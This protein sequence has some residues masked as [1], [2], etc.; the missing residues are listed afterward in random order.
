MPFMCYFGL[1]L[2]CTF[3]EVEFQYPVK[4]R[5]VSYFNKNISIANSEISF[6]W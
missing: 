1:C 3:V 4:G 2:L 5:S 6:L